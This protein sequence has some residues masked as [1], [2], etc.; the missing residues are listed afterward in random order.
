MLLLKIEINSTK[1]QEYLKCQAVWVQ[2]RG[3]CYQQTTIQ[4]YTESG[5]RVKNM[6]GGEGLDQ[7]DQVIENFIPL[8]HGD[9]L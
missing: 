1:P 7:S 8:P 3:I 5:E 4:L 6:G 9:A 2:I